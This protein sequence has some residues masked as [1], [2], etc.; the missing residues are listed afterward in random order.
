[1]VLIPLPV[2]VQMVIKE[3]PS[4]SL[5]QPFWDTNK[6]RTIGKVD[7]MQMRT[8]IWP[9]DKNQEKKRATV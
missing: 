4:I 8:L 7:I 6:N 5:T 3:M 1:M 2:L 9:V